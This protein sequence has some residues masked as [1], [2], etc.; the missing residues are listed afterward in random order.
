M[1]G[2]KGLTAEQ[3]LI[4]MVKNELNLFYKQL[5]KSIFSDQKRK[6]RY[7]HSEF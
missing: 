1:N 7:Y 2:S 3:E 6:N 4:L 5:I